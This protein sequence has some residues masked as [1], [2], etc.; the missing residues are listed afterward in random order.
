MGKNLYDTIKYHKQQDVVNTPHD[1]LEYVYNAM[2]AKG[3]DP[4]D[5]LVGYFL[6]EDPT[7]VTSY[8]NA[9][10]VICKLERYDLI[11][12]L[13]SFYIDHNLKKNGK[14]LK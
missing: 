11:E 6:S 5:Q 9:R 12:E 3:Y 4:V 10:N 13:V 8:D 7:Y 1:V 2:L 14:K